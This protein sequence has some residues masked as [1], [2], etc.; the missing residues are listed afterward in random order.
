MIGSSQPLQEIK[1]SLQRFA[2]S[3]CTVLISGE[4]GTGKEL[5]AEYVHRNSA[6]RDRPF[7][8]INCAA[9]PDSLFENELFGHSRGAF[10][11]ADAT[12]DGLLAAANGGTV[13][14]D[15]IGDMSLTA[16][17]KI[18]HVLERKEVCRIG[19]TRATKLDL[20]FVAATNQDL[21]AMTA[22]GTFRK[23]LF[24]RLSVA[25]IHLP[26]LRERKEDLP[27]LLKHYCQ[28]FNPT[29]GLRSI[30]FSD[31][32]MRVLLKYDW[33]GNI[34]ELKNLAESLCIAA[35]P[36]P[37]EPQHLPA[38][39]RAIAH[40]LKSAAADPERESLISALSWSGGNKA[41]AARRLNCSRM[42]LYRKL[43]KHRLQS[44]ALCETKISA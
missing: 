21:E 7:I 2:A 11:G 22:Q 20:R 9:I 16:Q 33:P 14:L 40:E 25:Q 34:R 12:C 26:A 6:R 27:L 37:I 35:I 30:E 29:P 42:T 5:A 23:D 19:S 4:T 36:S 18:L 41:A 3:N 28:E 24:F 13:F 17:A 1:L 31:E 10:T 8:C 32:C 15:E 44:R 38:R 43:S 39:F